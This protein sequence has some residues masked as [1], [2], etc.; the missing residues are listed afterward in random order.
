[1][2]PL[3][4]AARRLRRGA[5]TGALLGAMACAMAT[6][7]AADAHRVYPFGGQFPHTAGTYLYLPY[8][9]VT[10][11]GYPNAMNGAM[12][13]WYRTPTRVWPYPTSSYNASK[14]DFYTY[15]YAGETFAGMAIN[16]PC[17]Q[18][19]CRYGWGEI[20]LNAPI[21]N[22]QSAFM[23]QAI[24]AHEV[25]HILGLS[26]ACGEAACPYGSAS[27]LMQWGQ[28]PYNVPQAHDIN[29]VNAIYR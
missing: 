2:F 10:N 19:G 7:P 22:G 29:D 14:V 20:Y 28:L 5:L 17:S 12:Y 23:Q 21:M 4:A 9:Q 18:A 27:T 24:V 26:H 25:G 3:T 1:M 13:A 11:A 16:K 8:M 6:V 15:N